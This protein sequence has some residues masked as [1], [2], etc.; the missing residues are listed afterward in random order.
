MNFVKDETQ[1]INGEK[2][3][4]VLEIIEK[5]DFNWLTEA[6]QTGFHGDF[7]L[8]NIIKTKDGY[9]LID[10]RQDFG[11][12]LSSGD[13]YYDL[14]KL[15]H[16]L[17][18][19][20]DLVDKEHFYVRHKANGDIECEILV[21]HSLAECRR[22]L[23]DFLNKNGYDKKKVGVLTALIWLNMSPLHHHPF[24]IFLF[25]FGKYHLWRA[26]NLG[27]LKE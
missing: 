3:P 23:V 6:K 14:A 4:P 7:I 20:H 1:I 9:A 16:N 22:V 2:I 5:I 8:E 21:K 27:A 25:H 26:L 12:L 17:M 24:N 10:W 18:V 15:N 11:G 13:M 19:N